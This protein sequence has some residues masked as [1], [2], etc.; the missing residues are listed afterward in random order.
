MKTP[1][2]TTRHVPTDDR[3]QPCSVADLSTKQIAWRALG[4]PSVTKDPTVKEEQTKTVGKETL[5][6]FVGGFVG[7][8]SWSN[9]IRPY[10]H[11]HLGSLLDLVAQTT[12][13]IVISMVFWYLLL[14]RIRRDRFDQITRI[15]LTQGRCASCGYKLEGLTPEPDNCIVCPECNAAW[16][17]TRVGSQGES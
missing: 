9:L 15:Y 3:D 7:W 17:H 16:K 12:F 14:N 1:T 13:C 5:V 8:I 2:K 11:K 10:T 6:A 4:L